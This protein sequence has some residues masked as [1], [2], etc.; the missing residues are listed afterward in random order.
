MANAPV[1]RWALQLALELGFRLVQFQ[2]DSMFLVS[3]WTNHKS[4]HLAFVA[5]DYVHLTFFFKFVACS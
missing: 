4:W 2:T 5:G 3:A 1:L